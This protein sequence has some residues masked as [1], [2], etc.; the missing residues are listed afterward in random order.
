MSNILL[1]YPILAF[2][3]P[4]VLIAIG[5]EDELTKCSKPA[6]LSGYYKNLK[7]IDSSGRCVIVEHGTKVSSI[8]PLWGFSLFHGQQLR[9]A[10]KFKQGNCQVNLDDFKKKI[11]TL[12]KADEY[13]WDSGGNFNEIINRIDASNSIK[14]INQFLY[15]LTYA[16]Y[17]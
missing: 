7:L 6:L 4:N 17:G 11:K 5:T 14:E 3:S 2:S 13:S 12:M 1:K 15:E 8:G 16:T 10:L 9:V